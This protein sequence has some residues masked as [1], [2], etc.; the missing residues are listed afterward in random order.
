MDSR[1]KEI[2]ETERKT[3]MEKEDSGER[4]REKER[5]G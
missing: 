1:Q 3:D 5:D 4:I 2:R